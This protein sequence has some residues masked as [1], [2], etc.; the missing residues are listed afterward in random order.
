[1]LETGTVNIYNI[2]PHT[3][4]L[5]SPGNPIPPSANQQLTSISAHKS[6]EGYAIDWSPFPDETRLL[7]GDN[8]GKIYHTMRT[9]SGS[10]TTD[11][12]AYTGHT[13]SIEEI[14]WSPS[15]KNVFAS[16]SSDGTVKI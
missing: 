8:N 14:Q 10:F 1:M 4:S 5:D 7:T 9:E 13:S 12:K 16:A 2:T 6:I 15:E 11:G 3:T